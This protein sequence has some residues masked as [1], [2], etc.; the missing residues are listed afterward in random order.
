M[1]HSCFGLKSLEFERLTLYGFSLI[2]PKG[3]V[4]SIDEKSSREDGSLRI[5]LGTEAMIN[6]VWGP[7]DKIKEKLPSPKDHAEY[8]LKRIKREGD[9]MKV[10]LL[11]VERADTDLHEAYIAHS[12]VTRVFG[13]FLIYKYIEQEMLSLHVYCEESGRF[14]VVYGITGPSIFPEYEDILRKIL[15]SFRCHGEGRVEV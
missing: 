14:F 4:V 3:W 1:G 9:V 11:S 6:V 13:A 12:R 2:Y 5:R 10:K 15:L 8:A 7:L